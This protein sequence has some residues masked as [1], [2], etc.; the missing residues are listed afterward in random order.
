MVKM[1]EAFNSLAP[2][3]ASTDVQAHIQA[4]MLCMMRDVASEDPEFT[5]KLE[6][7]G[8]SP[9][10]CPKCGADYVRNGVRHNKKGPERTYRCKGPKRH[11]FVFN[12]GFEGRRYPN[13]LITRAVRLYCRTGSVRSVASELTSEGDEGPHYSTVARWVHDMVSMTVAY[14]QNLGMKGTGHICSTDEIV[15]DVLGM[16]SC[17][18]TVLDYESRF[19]LAVE[20][21]RTKDGQNS[22]ELFRAARKM[23]GRDPLITL[24]DSLEAIGNGHQAVF[25]ANYCSILVRD[26][27]IHN[28]RRTSNRHERFNSTLRGMVGGRRGR[29]SNVVIDAV[30]LYYNYIRPHMALGDITP[31][32]KAGM[33]IYG[34]NRLMTLSAGQSYSTKTDLNLVLAWNMARHGGRNR[35]GWHPSL[36]CVCRATRRRVHS[37][38]TNGTTDQ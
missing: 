12:P 15:E 34:P 32:Q 13:K 18:S 36:V 10:A 26:A 8:E 3:E 16:G 29:L 23:T 5:I 21:S 7:A 27:H 31:A 11:R 35:V 19:C 25:G 2:Q 9:P 38:H 6:Q 28:Q 20:V 4:L 24:S 22:A 30:W 14:L 33:F 17:V 1:A 37:S